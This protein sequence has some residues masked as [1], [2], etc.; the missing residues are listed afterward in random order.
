MTMSKSEAGRKRGEKSHGSRVD[1]N[2]NASQKRGQNLSE[3]G[4]EGGKSSR[5]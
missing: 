2:K 4:R 5:R 3:A 1:S